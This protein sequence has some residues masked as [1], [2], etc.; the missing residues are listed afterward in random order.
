MGALVV[1]SNNGE[2]KADVD[3][4]TQELNQSES[5]VA[6]DDLLNNAQAIL[7]IPKLDST[8]S[9]DTQ[10]AVELRNNWTGARNRKRTRDPLIKVSEKRLAKIVLNILRI[11]GNDLK[12]KTSDFEVSV[13][14]SPQDNMS[15]KAM[16][17]GYLL[18]NGVH[19]K[20]AISRVGLFEDADKVYLQSKPYLDNLWKT[21]DDATEEDN[22]DTTSTGQYALGTPFTGMAEKEAGGE[23][24]G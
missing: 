16:T 24:K 3:I 23:T 14:D 17:M 4:L 5:Q 18:Q 19:P 2:N 9:G 8:S 10:G 11:S 7:A 22:K 12:L 1:K 20:I 6:K 15:V 13:S 21:I